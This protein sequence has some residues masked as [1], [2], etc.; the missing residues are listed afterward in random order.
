VSQRLGDE[1]REPRSVAAVS[2]GRAATTAASCAGI[3]RRLPVLSCG[4]D[5]AG[6]I[7]AATPGPTSTFGRVA[8]RNAGAGN[9][10]R[11]DCHHGSLEKPS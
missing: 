9:S 2:H 1:H 10:R 6:E 5:Q 8:R 11:I 3:A 4:L 7:E